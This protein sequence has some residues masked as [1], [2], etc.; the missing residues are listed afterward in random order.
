MST[1]STG[2]AAQQVGHSF[3]LLPFRD[4]FENFALDR[5]QQRF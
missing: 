5:L 2:P 1:T 3:E 4:A